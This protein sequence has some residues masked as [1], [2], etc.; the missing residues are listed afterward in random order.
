MNI[1]DI[2]DKDTGA[3]LRAFVVVVLALISAVVAVLQGAL[4]VLQTLPDWDHM[5]SA[6]TF[7]SGAIVFLGR[8]TA[9]GNKVGD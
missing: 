5:A 4:D 3:K 2:F 8:F 9:L 7:I 6:A 1:L